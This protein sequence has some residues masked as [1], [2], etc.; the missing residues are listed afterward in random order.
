M[1]LKD[2]RQIGEIVVDPENSDVVF[3]AAEGS[4]WGP[5]ENADYI[6]L[7]TEERT[8]TKYWK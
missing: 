6:K 3:V 4:V 2:S 7:P 1:G 8:G 5:G